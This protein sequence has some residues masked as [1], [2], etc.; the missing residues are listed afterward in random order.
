MRK[1]E[2]L[3]KEDIEWI[4]PKEALIAVSILDD[5]S[6][7]RFLEV[8]VLNAAWSLNLLRNTDS[9]GVGIDP[10]PN[11]SQMRE[12]TLIK[13]ERHIYVFLENFE[14]LSNFDFFDLIHIDGE[15][16]FEAVYKDLT[17]SEKHLSNRGVIVI[18]DV[19]HSSFPGVAAAFFSWLINSDFAPFLV[20][21]S[22]IYVTLKSNHSYWYRHFEE[23]FTRYPEFPWMRY[24]GEG[25]SLAYISKP[26]IGSYTTLLSPD[27]FIPQNLSSLLPIWPTQ[28]F[29]GDVFQS[30][31]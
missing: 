7:K 14:N 10:Y 17:Y 6:T 12:R 15:H 4:I 24:Y 28:P 27:K 31:D 26:D 9:H 20:T 5:F 3:P 23:N 13:L 1:L 19:W 2:F 8:G 29:L 30:R 25:K 18:D 11:L 16:T 21:G 22:K